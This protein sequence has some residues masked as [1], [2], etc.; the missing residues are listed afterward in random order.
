M[1]YLLKDESFENKLSLLALSDKNTLNSLR[2][3]EEFALLKLFPST[4]DYNIVRAF[5]I[6]PKLLNSKRNAQN[7]HEL[8][9]FMQ[10]LISVC[11]SLPNG[12]FILTDILGNLQINYSAKSK[13][14]LFNVSNNTMALS[15]NIEI[16][17]LHQATISF[18]ALNKLRDVTDVFPAVFGVFRC[19]EVLTNSNYCTHVNTSNYNYILTEQIKGVSINDGID[20]LLIGTES[21][22]MYFDEKDLINVY[23]VLAQVVG[24][25]QLAYDNFKYKHGSLSFDTI[26]FENLK[27]ERRVYIGNGSCIDSDI[28][29]YVLPSQ[30]SEIDGIRQAKTVKETKGTVEETKGT[31]AENDELSDIR[32]LLNDFSNKYSEDNPISELLQSFLG[33]STNPTFSYL[34]QLLANV[35]TRHK[36]PIYE[37]INSVYIQK[38]IKLDVNS[39]YEDPAHYLLLCEYI[40]NLNTSIVSENAIEIPK[41]SGSIQLSETIKVIGPQLLEKG[42][43]GLLHLKALIDARSFANEDTD[44]EGIKTLLELKM[45]KAL[46]NIM[47][48]ETKKSVGKFKQETRVIQQKVKTIQRSKYQQ[49]Q[50]EVRKNIPS[51]Y[52]TAVKTKP[53]STITTQQTS[54]KGKPI[55]TPVVLFTLKSSTEKLDEIILELNKKGTNINKTRYLNSRLL[56]ISE[57]ALL[58]SNLFMSGNWELFKKFK[59]N[60]SISFR[61]T[62]IKSVIDSYLAISEEYKKEG[63]TLENLKQDVLPFIPE[64]YYE[65]VSEVFLK[66]KEG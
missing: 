47:D 23:K 61:S 19:S 54:K 59:S 29:L 66:Y 49:G 43:P 48:A 10:R 5:K 11:S 31:V 50:K 34:T 63:W 35:L 37:N 14:S 65:D 32:L 41:Y 26:Y 1:E 62:V 58:L 16:D 25:L 38:P 12:Q 64:M 28:K 13:I 18:L 42:I 4:I 3:L 39:E 53:K 44:I 36:I 46:K 17:F 9:H 55:N 20:T 60:K 57:Y 56:G 24:S 21:E 40:Y 6:L 22:G 45:T 30:L 52:H 2:I 8:S 51:V 33:S 15:H 7:I 27:S